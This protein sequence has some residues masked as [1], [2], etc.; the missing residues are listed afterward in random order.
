MTEKFSDFFLLDRPSKASQDADLVAKCL[1]GDEEAWNALVDKY[2]NLVW[3]VPLK[4]RL[5]HEDCAD[6]FQ[7]VWLDLF[8]DLKNLR[9]SG[10]VRSWLVSAASHKCFH[11]K[12][13]QQSLNR[14]RETLSSQSEKFASPP[15]NL[16]IELEREQLLREAM[17]VLSPRCQELVNMLFFEQPP[18]PYDDVAKAMGLA[19]GSIGFIRGRCLKKLREWLTE[20]EF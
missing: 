3:S 20:R 4:Y 11:W 6:I 5:N 13:R 1:E 2:K 12:A 14:M 19:V 17:L 7:A 18:R 9:Y 8:Q 16:S 15:A 10:A